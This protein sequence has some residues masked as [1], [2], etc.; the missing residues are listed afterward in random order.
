MIETA[1]RIILFTVLPLALAGIVVFFDMS[2]WSKSRRY[3]A[4]L[5]M[6]FAIGV[7]G[8]GIS[9]F[10]AHFFLSDA[11]AASIGWK[12]GSPFQLEVAFANLAMGILGLVAVSRRDG[13]REATVIAVTVFGV[14]ATIVHII[15]ILATGNLEPGNTVQNVS[16]LLKPALL[17][18]TLV[19]SR[20]AD[21]VETGL[22]DLDRWRATLLGA[23]AP[24]T[25]CIATA[26]GLGYALGQPA[27]FSLIGALLAGVIL[28]AAL[29]RSPGHQLGWE[30]RNGK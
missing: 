16:N 2:A 6:L 15:D 23:T 22:D 18:F 30:G 9:N 4:V 14:G 25:V 5:V 3:E 1:I 10:L 19:Q 26:Y 29:A 8:S 11:V 27:L 20:R 12:P 21:E 17:I 24:I 13:F 7:A 28:V